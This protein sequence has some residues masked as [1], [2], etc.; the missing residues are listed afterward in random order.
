[1]ITTFRL[2]GSMFWSRQSQRPTGSGGRWKGRG[3]LSVRARAGL[4]VGLAFLAVVSS[5][6]AGSG[7]TAPRIPWEVPTIPVGNNPNFETVNQST[8]TL[9]V[10]SGTDGTISVVDSGRCNSRN[11]SQCRPLATLN[12]SGF[13][14]LDPATDT[15]YVATGQSV[16]VVDASTCNAENASGCG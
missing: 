1:T 9:Y 12:I 8:R 16:D 5:A 15:L 2:G 13:P 11:A 7:G 4:V 3:P 6:L 14:A 10:A